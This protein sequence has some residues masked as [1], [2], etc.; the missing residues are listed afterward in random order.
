MFIYI[1]TYKI[2]HVNK[3]RNFL[4]LFVL[5]RSCFTFSGWLEFCLLDSW[6][7]SVE[8]QFCGPGWSKWS[9]WWCSWSPKILHLGGGNV[10]WSTLPQV[11]SL[12]YVDFC[13]PSFRRRDI[14]SAMLSHALAIHFS[15]PGLPLLAAV[16]AGV[17]RVWGFPGLFCVV[18]LLY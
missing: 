9:C 15:M 12:P 17:L 11:S 5:S 14:V 8:E 2:T 13:F 1:Y 4:A 3:F 7:V 18:L 10:V 6:L 16:S